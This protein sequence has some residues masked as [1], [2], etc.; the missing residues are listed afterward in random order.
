MKKPPLESEI[1]ERRWLSP[2]VMVL[3][4]SRPDAFEFVPGQRVKLSLGGKKRPYNIASIPSDAFLELCVERVDDGMITPRL[5]ELP[6]GASVFLRNR[7]K[8]RLAFEPGR[9]EHLMVATVM[10]IAPFR[11]I[12]LH[13]LATPTDDS[14]F[15]ILHG[16]RTRDELVYREELEAIAHEHPDRLRYVPV[17]SRAAGSANADPANAGWQRETGDVS[18]CAAKWADRL[19]PRETQVYA[20]GHPAMIADVRL[21]YRRRDF[22]VVTEAFWKI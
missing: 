9:R 3:R 10:G 17:V 4:V 11:S 5:W 6:E 22:S 7:A 15:T 2:D 13:E 20:C 19:D 16:A 8:G 18:A 14:R 12:L 21:A 1:L